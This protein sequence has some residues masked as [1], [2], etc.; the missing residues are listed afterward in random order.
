VRAL[1]D[2][3]WLSFTD[4]IGRQLRD[5]LG[6]PN[7]NIPQEQLMSLLIR[8]LSDAFANSGGN[9]NDYG[10]PK[11][12]VQC[13]FV[14][15]NRLINDEIDPE[16]LM[17]SM[18]ADSLV[19]QLNA[20]QRTVYDTIVGRVYSSSPDFS[21]S[22][23]M[24]AQAKPPMEHHNRKVMFRTKNSACSGLLWCRIP[25]FAQRAHCTFKI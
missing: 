13:A 7:Y 3:Y 2:T 20:D 4:D 23:A 14:D 11:I 1:F 18:L 8:K 9:I 10:L 21:L 15:E 5:T 24:V 17:L 22:V 25:T 16:P 12:D 19:T 6:N